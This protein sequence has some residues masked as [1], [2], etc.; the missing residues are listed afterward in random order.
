MFQRKEACTLHTGSE[1][2]LNQSPEEPESMMCSPS[3]FLL[4][5]LGCYVVAV[6]LLPQR[7]LTMMACTLRPRRRK[8]SLLPVA[9]AVYFDTAM[10][11]VTNMPPACHT[12]IIKKK[13]RTAG[14]K[15]PAFNTQGCVSVLGPTSGDKWLCLSRCGS[16]QVLK[17][18]SI[19]WC[20]HTEHLLQCFQRRRKQWLE[21]GKFKIGYQ[22]S[23]LGSQPG[24]VRIS[25]FH[26]VQ[27]L[28]K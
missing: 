22:H 2:R 3:V 12:V 24:K 1:L 20:H 21:L 17:E 27:L 23:I 19:H 11:Q 15:C 6:S 13:M 8:P 16:T 9:S 28:A 25:T 26:V 7:F 4:S 10:G 5:D 14:F 18:E